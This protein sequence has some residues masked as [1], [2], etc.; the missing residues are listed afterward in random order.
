MNGS[1]GT[2]LSVK[3][4]PGSSRDEIDGWLAG[5]LKLRVAA[6]PE[7]GRANAAVEKLLARALGVTKKSVRVVVGLTSARKVVEIDG[8]SQEDVRQRLAGVR[9]ESGSR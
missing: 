5:S 4:V 7:K 8:L 3:V 1:R 9:A 2:R 6:P